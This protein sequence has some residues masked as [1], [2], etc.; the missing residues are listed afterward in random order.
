MWAASAAQGSRGG[1]AGAPC[2]ATQQVRDVTEEPVPERLPEELAQEMGWLVDQTLEGKESHPLVKSEPLIWG[3]GLS[4]RRMVQ[5]SSLHSLE[6]KRIETPTGGR[7]IKIS[8][9]TWR[10]FS[11]ESHG[12]LSLPHSP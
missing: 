3:Q 8:A 2:T 12:A 7:F 10:L 5:V 6:K 11:L 9:L 1:L 4:G